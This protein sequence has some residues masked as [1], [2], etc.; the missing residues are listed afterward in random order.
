MLRWKNAKWNIEE[1]GVKAEAEFDW[2]RTDSNSWLY[3]H[4]V[5]C[6]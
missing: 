1:Y 5:E 3:E 6:Y 2:F 4:V